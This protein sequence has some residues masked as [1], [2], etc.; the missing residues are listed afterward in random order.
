MD[1]DSHESPPGTEGAMGLHDPVRL[2][3]IEI[4]ETVRA[5]LDE[6]YMARLFDD[7]IDRAFETFECPEDLEYSPAVFLKTVA[8]FVQHMHEHGLAGRRRLSQSQASDEAVA[9]L[10]Q[11][12]EIPGDDGYA[13]AVDAAAPHR[14]GVLA[15]LATL[16]EALKSRERQAYLRWVAVRYIDAAGWDRKCAMA[17]VLLE[18]PADRLPS[19]LL[20]CA[21]EQLARRVFKLLEADVA[22]ERQSQQRFL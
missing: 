11:A 22:T 1:A 18:R 10:Q 20:G 8:D 5:L 16:A 4:I 15:V 7:P 6:E 12:Y 3:A 19:D 9:L 14:A 17:A 2:R 13:A 21:P